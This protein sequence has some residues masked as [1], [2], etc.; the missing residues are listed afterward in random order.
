M[1]TIYGVYRSRAL[2]PIW[3]LTETGTPFE[4]VPVIQAYRL[5]DP[6]APDAPRNT[7]SPEFLKVNPAGQVPAMTEEGLVLTESLAIT[8]HLARRHGGTLGPADETE[9][10]LMENWA[11]V[12]ATAVE[13]PALEI[14]YVVNA[15]SESTPE[16]AAAIEAAAERLRR[17]LRRLEAHFERAEPLRRR[18]VHGGGSQHGRVPALRA[19]PPDAPVRVSRDAALAGGLPG[20]PRLPDRLGK[21]PGRAALSAK[22]EGGPGTVGVAAYGCWTS[23]RRRAAGTASADIAA[24][25]AI[26]V[27]V[28]AS[29]AT[30]A[31]P[32]PAS[33][34]TPMTV[35]ESAV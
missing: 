19:E 3:L 8:L 2:R 31:K 10:A 6:S 13:T 25:S 28:P 4:H 9:L 29:S 21:A 30:T 24:R 18:K 16:G 7:A 22:D 12:G 11:L 33:R 17:P 5:A 32:P 26:T 1:I 14:M 34:S 35:F 20:A 15:G 27:A 23:D